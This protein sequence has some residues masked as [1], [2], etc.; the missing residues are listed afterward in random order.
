MAKEIVR[1]YR[2]SQ[3]Q[4]STLSLNIPAISSSESQ[5]SSA[6]ELTA[7]YVP[8]VTDKHQKNSVLYSQNTIQNYATITN[9]DKIQS[10]ET[11]KKQNYSIS[12]ISTPNYHSQHIPIT[13]SSRFN[14]NTPTILPL[15]GK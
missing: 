9:N 2:H 3:Y 14:L 10:C 6:I 7:K 4:L 13:S 11:Q 12:T 15:V 5:T 8:S 1:I